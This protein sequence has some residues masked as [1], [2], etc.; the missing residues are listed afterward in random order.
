MAILS[1]IIGPGGVATLQG[2]QTLSNK[3]IAPRVVTIADATS[4]TMNGDTTDLAIQTNTQAA[5]TLTINAPTGTPTD[6]QKII[7]RMQCTN[8][9][10]L[11]FNAVFTGSAD[12]GLPPNTTGSGKYD[13]LGFIYNS[14]ASKWQMIA[15]NFGH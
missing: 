9:Q 11:S 14:A 13:Y 2:T 4:I 7:L 6:G 3:R 8:I 1:N 10:T 12:L 5:G 15:K